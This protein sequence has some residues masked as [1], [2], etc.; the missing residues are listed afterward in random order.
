MKV[1]FVIPSMSGGGAERVISILANELIKR[2]M[3]ISI[4]MTAGSECAYELDPAVRVFQTGER[5]DGSMRKRMGRLSKM[6]TY[7]KKNRNDILVAFEPDA[8]FWCS[9]AKAGLR[10][11]M[12]SSERNDP[13]SFGKNRARK[14]A[15][16]YSD[17][18]VFQTEEARDFF[19]KRI[20]KKGCIIANPLGENLPAPYTGE[21]KKTI[22][23]VGRLEIQKNHAVLLRAFAGF[24]RDYPDYT[25]HLYGKGS[26]EDSLKELAT[27][28]EI[29]RKVIFEGFRKNVL[30]EIR[31]AGM[32][33][34]SSDYEG[35]S[36]SL[37]E[38]MAV[39]LPVIS[40]DCPCGGSR[41]CI[42]DG[43]NGYLVPVG[44][45]SSLSAAMARLAADGENSARM[46]REAVRI[47]SI[48]SVDNI[49]SQWV[50]LLTESEK[51]RNRG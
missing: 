35:I 34:L 7:L 28:L 20:R 43:V 1:T 24:A 42:R 18:I 2:G 11:S 33:V 47:R 15:Y 51:R 12:I 14:I 36:N 8:A 25:L 48:F 30:R 4:L 38:A 37:L 19:S 49:V 32:F 50:E 17:R 40:T 23:C 21:R 3:E 41:L 13:A 5:T 27:H 16:E 44:D 6:R 46:G 9:I 22:V 45:A 10:I 29:E 39:G 31:D 26:L